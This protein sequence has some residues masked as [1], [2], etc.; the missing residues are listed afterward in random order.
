[1]KGNLASVEIPS[2]LAAMISN[3]GFFPKRSTQ[4][5]T[6]QQAKTGRRIYLHRWIDL[7]RIDFPSLE[8]HFLSPAAAS[9]V[10]IV[11]FQRLPKDNLFSLDAVRG[12]TCRARKKVAKKSPLQVGQQPGEGGVRKFSRVRLS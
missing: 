7:R 3:R 6:G 10:A 9:E 5:N 4:R 11:K 1:M 12:Q 8:E 2:G